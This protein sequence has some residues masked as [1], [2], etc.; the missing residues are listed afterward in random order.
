MAARM[1][2]GFCGALAVCALITLAVGRDRAAAQTVQTPSSGDGRVDALLA[3]MTLAEKILLIHGQPEPYDGDQGEAGF[4]PGLPRLGIPP[5]RLAD[6]PPGVLT[7]YPATALPAT[8]ALAATFSSQDAERSGAVIGSDARALGID[9]V[10]EPYINIHRDQTFH[11]AYN[12][13]G[14]DPL[15]TGI[16]GAGVIRGV[17]AKGVMAQAKHYVGYD[18]ANDVTMD[19]QTLHEIYLAPFAAAAAA[20]VS[21]VMCS[22]NL[23]N[24][25]YSCGN[26][27]ALALLRDTGFDG[28]VTSDWG[29]VHATD[30]ITAG[31]DLEMPGSGT[32]MSS[33][34]EGNLP[35]PTA[36]RAF[37]P[38]PVLTT[39]PE[40][41]AASYPPGPKG[42]SEPPVG[43]LSAVQAGGV[44]EAAIT[45][46]AGDILKQVERFGLLGRTGTRPVSPA[47][48][49][50]NTDAVRS[51]AE[52]GAVL[53]KNEGHVLPLSASDLGSVVFI[54]PGAGQTIATGI[55]GEKA[56]GFVERQM[57]TVAALQRDPALKGV[58]LRYVVA[59]DMDGRSIAA[60]AWTHGGQAGLLRK[61]STGQHID[62]VLEFTRANGRA[63]PAGSSAEWT[64]T[65]RV[66]TAGRY[67]LYLEVIGASASLSLDGAL[68]ARTS[69]LQLHGNVLQPAQD[70]VL[71]T[72]DGLD[73]VRRE[74]PL[75]AGPHEIG[76][77]IEGDASG[78]PVQVRLRWVTPGEMQADYQA[79][80]EAARHASRAVV[81]VWSRN[82]PAFALPGDQDKLVADVARV[83]PNTVVVMNLSEPVALPWLDRIKAL[84]LMWY[85]G[86]EGGPA[87]ANVLL[88][89]A[90][91]AGRLP[92]TWPAQ[93]A[94]NVANDPSHP[95][96]SSLGVDGHTQYS[97][98]ID[99]G[100]R[101]FDREQL[102][103]QFPFGFGLSYTTFD[104]SN[105]SVHAAADGGLDV[106]FELRNSGSRDGDEVPQV[107]LGPPSP[108]PAGAQF[109]PQA[110]AAFDR[111]HLIAGQSRHLQL[112]VAPRALQYWS[113]LQRGWVRA[114]GTRAVSVAT[115]SRDAR[116]TVNTAVT[117]AGAGAGAGASASTGTGARP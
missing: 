99:V 24:G 104:Y 75:T 74:L 109:A 16:I 66:P 27:D 48:P 17:Q 87:T 51:L 107:Y 25:P 96:R 98:G 54:G 78:S 39:I 64:G 6:G 29:A 14:E 56:L 28:F 40:E 4:L 41:P 110:L 68:L 72:T 76:V 33:Y 34:F 42:R 82:L 55:S 59:D 103:P 67:R 86:D 83:N 80:V 32:V 62:R 111:V 53:L 90:N 44:S 43:M 69:Q 47:P 73:N 37:L 85:P 35:G 65:L 106:G 49:G 91:P 101:W 88:G 93:L 60:S 81:F 71:P 63:L 94:Q 9:V 18:G 22:Y 36:P 46:A 92:I 1:R 31:L 77:K 38:A 21:S 79:A 12:T 105:L 70:N 100:Y 108:Q 113:S 117:P 95:E 58:R 5:L 45:R 112:H 15:L 11:R 2:L 50:A 57:G 115:S 10:L 30:F 61:D 23:I 114:I 116:L 84:L 3:Q 13:Y 20:Q 102:T 97:E 8:M 26:H 19:G 89:R 52:D 7:R